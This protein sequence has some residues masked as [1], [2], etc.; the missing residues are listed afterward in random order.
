MSNSQK[1]WYQ[2]KT[3][4]S[5]IAKIVAGILSSIAAILMGDIDFQTFFTGF[6]AAIW[7]IYDIV[8]RFKTNSIIKK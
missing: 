3:V 2:S 8:I 1:K 5:G 6:I 7:G 4:W